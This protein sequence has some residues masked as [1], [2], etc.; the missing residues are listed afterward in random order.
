MFIYVSELC[1]I[2]PKSS[3]WRLFTDYVTTETSYHPFSLSFPYSHCPSLSLS[4]YFSLSLYFSLY[5]FLSLSLAVYHYSTHT[6]S[7]SLS[8]IF[9]LLVFCLVVYLDLLCWTVLASPWLFLGA[10][11]CVWLEIIRSSGQSPATPHHT[12]CQDLLYAVWC[13]LYMYVYSVSVYG[14]NQ[15]PSYTHTVNAS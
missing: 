4:I 2:T 10:S 11:S 13:I 5:L 8:Q 9:A 6:R 3:Y 1:I 7:L 12:I 14:N 15:R